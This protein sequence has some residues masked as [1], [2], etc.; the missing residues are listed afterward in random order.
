M[1]NE[2]DNN[3]K[4][5]TGKIILYTLLVLFAAGSIGLYFTMEDEKDQLV[6]KSTQLEE[7]LQLRDSA[8]NEIIDIMYGVE[9][10]IEK[11]KDRENIITDVTSRDFNQS[12]KDRM[13][14]DCLLYTSPSPRD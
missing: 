7:E 8:Y 10:K 1:E 14:K 12:D 6:E 9:T 3:G 5:Q 11:I 2:I 13:I 4:T